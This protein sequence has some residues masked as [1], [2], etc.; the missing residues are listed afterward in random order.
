MHAHAVFM[1]GQLDFLNLDEELEVAIPEDS[2]V[3]IS[4][5]LILLIYPTVVMFNLV[6][7]L[8]AVMQNDH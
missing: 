2:K 4:K 1:E 5:I 7:K 6:M 3:H 8:G